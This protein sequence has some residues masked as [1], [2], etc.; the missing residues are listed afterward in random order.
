[1]YTVKLQHEFQVHPCPYCHEES[2]EI[3][4]CVVGQDGGKHMVYSLDCKNLSCFAKGP[5]RDDLHQAITNHNEVGEIVAAKHSETQ[6]P[7]KQETPTA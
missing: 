6:E 2:M 7:E 4:S 1:M 5:N 3:F